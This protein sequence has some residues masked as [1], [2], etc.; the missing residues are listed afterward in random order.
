MPDTPLFSVIIP[1][2]H[3]NDALRECLNALSPDKQTLSPDLYEVII[4]D[5]G[6]ASTAEALIAAEFPWARWT[7]GPQRGPAANRNHGAKQAR[8]H[9]FIFTDD[10]CVPTSGFVAGYQKAIDETGAAAYE[11]K[12]TCNE[13]ITS[14]LYISPVNLTGGCFWSCNIM[15]ER[16]LFEQMHGFDENFAV[17]NNEDTDMRERLK[18]SGVVIAFAD[19]ATVNHPPRLR[20]MGDNAGKL[21]ESI[22]QMWYMTGNRSPAKISVKL[23]RLIVAENVSWVRRYPLGKD[24]I[25]SLGYGVREFFYTAA[26]LP[27]WNQTY[28]EKF[29]KRTAAYPYPY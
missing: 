3:R 19:A 14:P 8:G 6:K 27:R 28:R 20:K 5:D 16:D 21:H 4:T 12:T 23:L 1:T 24:S 25:A 17:A 22:V 13:G 7:K 11:G 29:A 10:D 15:M 2:Y 26:H 9:W 18:H